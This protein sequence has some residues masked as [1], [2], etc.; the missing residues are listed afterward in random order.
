MRTIG[1]PH[2]AAVEHITAAPLLGAGFHRSDVRAGARL[3]HRQRPDMR[4][5][6]QLGQVAR[7]LLRAA[8]TADLVDAEIRMCA[9]GKPDR[10]GRA[11]NLLHR[12]AMLEI[13]ETGT[14]K[15]L[16]DGDAEKTERAE[17]WPE[18]A[19]EGIVAVER[20]GA[21]RDLAGREA[22]HAL[23]QQIGGLAQSE[24]EVTQSV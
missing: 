18:V 7:L 23:A 14:A 5:G 15:F 12:H 17:I 16:L 10:R 3:R 8:V 21:R 20:I 9:V 22:T 13:T 11:R 19:R 1:D 4:T 24:I 2:L 6:H